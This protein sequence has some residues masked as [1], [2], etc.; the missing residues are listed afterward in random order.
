MN[1]LFTIRDARASD[2]DEVRALFREYVAWLGVDLCF[3]SF[4]DELATLPGRYARARRGRLFVAESGG[5]IVGV[6]GLRDLGDLGDSV[7]EMKRLFVR[8]QGRGHGVGRALAE[9]LLADA[10]AEGYR[11]MRLDTLPTNMLAANALYESLGFRDIPPYYA[12]P[13]P[14]VRYLECEL[15]AA[16]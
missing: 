1:D 4:D 13:V 10:R 15:A 5:A 2:M 14:G 12:N 3:Q 16:R 9:R 11:A 6:I 7:C 8:E